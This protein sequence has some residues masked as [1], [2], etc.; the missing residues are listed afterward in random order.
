MRIAFRVDASTSMGSGHAMRCL[1]L[2]EGLRQRGD[3]VLFV[4]RRH[5]GHLCELMSGRGFAVAALPPPEASAQAGAAPLVAAEK[6]AHAGWVGAPWQVDAEQT[7]A[8]L[9]SG[10]MWDWLVVDHYGLDARWESAMRPLVHAVFAIDDLDDR[11][12]DADLILDQGFQGGGGRYEKNA[13]RKAI[14][15]LGPRYALLREEFAAARQALR[16][17][18]GRLQRLLVYFGAYDA[19]GQTSRTIRALRQAALPGLQVDVVMGGAAPERR[20]VEAAC[21]ELDRAVLH[22][23]PVDMAAM[24][25]AADLAIGAAGTTTWERCCLGLPSL[26][27]GVAWNQI[28][29]AESLARDGACIYLGPAEQVTERQIADTVRALALNPRW[30]RL[31]ARRCH[32]LVDGAG[33]RRVL[34]QL[35]P[36]GMRLRPATKQ[37]AVPMFHWRNAPEN[38]RFAF[39]PAPLELESHLAWV[40]AALGA[41][42]R[43]LLVAERGGQPVGVLRYD[44]A[45]DTARVSI[46]LGPGCHGQG[47]GAQVLAAG[48]RWM[49]E[50][51][52]NVELLVAEIMPANTAS[53]QAFERAGYVASSNVYRQ[54]LRKQQG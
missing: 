45:G 20:L 39:D 26:V 23:T 29:M 36:R 49:R 51:R 17:R 14:L 13:G 8:A 3:E 41:A 52:G 9:R 35:S 22:E 40:E 53:I 48:S 7:R 34:G 25:A 30:L 1:T 15:L 31:L 38:R 44:V 4:S 47:L 28:E 10:A 37:D 2:A 42:D 33:T 54:S 16:E 11:D 21:R 18:D 50:H 43:I 32:G 12:H 19:A 27:V 6:P 24:M 5:P 46:Y